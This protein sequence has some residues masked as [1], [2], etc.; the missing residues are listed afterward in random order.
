MDKFWTL[1]IYIRPDVLHAAVSC[2]HPG[3]VRWGRLLDAVFAFPRPVRYECNQGYRLVGDSTLYCQ[4]NGRWSGTKPEC[5][6]ECPPFS[7]L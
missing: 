5:H 7:T 4:S 3:E 1:I 6:S 2:G